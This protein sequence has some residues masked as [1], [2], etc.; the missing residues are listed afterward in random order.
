MNENVTIHEIIFTYGLP[1]LT[2]FTSLYLA[3]KTDILKDDSNYLV[4]PYSF[5]RTQLLWWTVIIICC[6]SAY[7]GMIDEIPELKS[8]PLVLLGISLGTTTTARIIDASEINN[9]IDR[10]Q[11]SNSKKGFIYNILSDANGISVHRFQAFVFNLIFGLIF[12]S[13]FLE[14]NDHQFVD[15]GTTELALM[16]IS[17][18]AYLGLKLNENTNTPPSVKSTSVSKVD[19]TN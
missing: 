7:F 8:T 6:F 15:F 9:S 17:S 11:D 1:L 18:A 5:A 14:S 4:K 2:I 3:V 19:N 12:I 16:G 13:K 10:H